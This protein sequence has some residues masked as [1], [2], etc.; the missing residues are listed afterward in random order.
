M[1]VQ[2]SVASGWRIT[3]AGQ[4]FE[5]PD[6]AL[7]ETTFAVKPWIRR[8]STCLDGTKW[9]D[10][11]YRIDV[12]S[13]S[14]T[15]LDCNEPTTYIAGDLNYSRISSKLIKIGPYL[16]KKITERLLD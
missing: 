11:V 8:T 9:D 13:V 1:V 12:I 4:S 6:G 15:I 14:T 2:G 16:P 7:G 5:P 10:R 3:R